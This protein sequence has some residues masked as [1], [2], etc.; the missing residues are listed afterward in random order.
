MLRLLLVVLFLSVYPPSHAKAQDPTGPVDLALV[1]ALDA[2]GSVNPDR[3]GLQLF[4]YAEAF[5][6]KEVLQAIK[7]GRYRAIAVTM[8]HWAG[9][10]EQRQVIQW[11]V[12]RDAISAADLAARI[13]HTRRAFDGSSTS[14]TGA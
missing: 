14:I 12:V 5:A 3:W 13:T 1:L 7:H 8:I 9:T 4:G 11:A 6:S 10:N 2:S